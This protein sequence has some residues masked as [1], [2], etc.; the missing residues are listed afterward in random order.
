MPKYY[1][2]KLEDCIVIKF[3]NCLGRLNGMKHQG[4]TFKCYVCA[5]EYKTQEQVRQYRLVFHEGVWYNCH[6]CDL[7]STY[8]AM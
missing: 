1:K 5:K 3:G 8:K 6:S 4:I 7:K 2:Q